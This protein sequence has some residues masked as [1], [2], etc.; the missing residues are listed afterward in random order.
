MADRTINWADETCWTWLDMINLTMAPGFRRG[1]RTME[2]FVKCERW[3]VNDQLQSQA[4]GRHWLSL[5]GVAS[6]GR[7]PPPRSQLRDIAEAHSSARS[8]FAL[9]NHLSAQGMRRSAGASVG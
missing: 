4:R 1:Y 9:H 3:D 2:T 8:D 6:L 7:S 5:A